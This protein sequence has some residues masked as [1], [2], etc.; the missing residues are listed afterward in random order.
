MRKRI[1]EI[2]EHLNKGIH[3]REEVIAVSLLA[4]LADQNIF[5][6]GPPGTAKSLISRRLSHA[7]E[8]K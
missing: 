3:E 7:F 5:L 2:L 6:L 1:S 8:T 4:A